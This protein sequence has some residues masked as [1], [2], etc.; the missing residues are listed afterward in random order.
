MRNSDSAKQ[1]PDSQ[2]LQ[3]HRNH[4]E[5][6]LVPVCR[7]RLVAL[8]Q[9]E[10]GRSAEALMLEQRGHDASLAVPARGQAAEL[11]IETLAVWEIEVWIKLPFAC[12]STW[13]QKGG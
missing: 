11:A 8:C 9:L 7:L 13:V 10:G 6:R 1:P 12:F 2:R 3:Q 5:R 4:V